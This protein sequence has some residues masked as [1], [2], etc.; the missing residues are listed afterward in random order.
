MRSAALS[1]AVDR[2]RANPTRPENATGNW[3]AVS[4]PK[5]SAVPDILQADAPSRPEALPGRFDATK[6]FGIVL[7]PIVEPVL[8]G[9]KSNEDARRL[10]VARD[11]DFFSLSQT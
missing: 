8:L 2:E 6:E 11:Y 3:R 1:P 4:D 9:L 5:S 10:P 7:E